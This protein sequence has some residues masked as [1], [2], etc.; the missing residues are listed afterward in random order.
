MRVI[1]YRMGF[2]L[3]ELLVVI[4]VIAV[5][6]AM[7]LPAVQSVRNAARRASCQNNFRQIGMA[8]ANYESSFRHLPAGRVGCD[9]TGDVMTL[10]DCPSGLQPAEKTGASGFV[11]ILAQIEQQSL[12]DNLNVASGGLWNRD[13][14][15][16]GWHD[17]PNKSEG[18]KQHLPVYWCPSEFANRISDV[19]FPVLAATS[20]YAFVNGSLGPESPAYITKYKNNGAFLYRTARAHKDITD[21]LSNTYLVGEVVQPDTWESSNVWTYTLANADCL[22]STSNPLNS[23]PGEGYTYELRNGAFASWHSGGALF[24]FADGHV[25]FVQDQ[26]DLMTYRSFSTIAGGETSGY[27][28]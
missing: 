10:E 16:L 20:S 24:L 21:G 18:V 25:E 17:I 3:V 23:K 5:L 4:A 6:I 26:I 28:K 7:L 11:T 15:D 19:Y 1:Y 13:V 22:R 27:E 12:S 14:D 8:V 9:D 2:T